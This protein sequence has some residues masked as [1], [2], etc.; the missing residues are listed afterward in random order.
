[1]RLL[2]ICNIIIG[3]CSRTRNITATSR[4]ESYV[5]EKYLNESELFEIYEH[6]K[7]LKIGIIHILF[8][9]CI[10]GSDEFSCRVKH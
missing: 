8:Q 3:F 9:H 4:R 1:M 2:H 7:G 6:A 10:L 5:V